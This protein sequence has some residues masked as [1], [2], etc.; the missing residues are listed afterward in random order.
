MIETFTIITSLLGV[1]RI[2]T[3]K[4]GKADYH[5]LFSFVA[6][7]LM[8]I[9]FATAVLTAKTWEAYWEWT[10]FI[11]VIVGIL[12]KRKGNVSWKK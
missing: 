5:A 9:L 2:M 7:I 6:S 4:R 11:M 8:T 10:I 12:F 3:Y 1:A